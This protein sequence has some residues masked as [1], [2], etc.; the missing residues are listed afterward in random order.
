MTE[1]DEKVV[2]FPGKPGFY[3]KAPGEF[4]LVLGNLEDLIEEAEVLESKADI[5]G[6]D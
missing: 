6:D 1:D 2:Y 4:K 5:E 3:K